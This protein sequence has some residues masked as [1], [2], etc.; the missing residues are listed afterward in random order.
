VKGATEASQPDIFSIWHH[1]WRGG[2]IRLPDGGYGCTSTVS[3]VVRPALTRPVGL[4]LARFWP[5]VQPPRSSMH[6]CYPGG[7]F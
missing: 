4:V 6:A 2:P 5:F 7:R 3:S 1:L